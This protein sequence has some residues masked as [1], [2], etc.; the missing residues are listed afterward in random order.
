MPLNTSS[1]GISTFIVLISTKLDRDEIIGNIH[2][3]FNL[4]LSLGNK[5]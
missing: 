4:N 2:P 5:V 1:E 3:S